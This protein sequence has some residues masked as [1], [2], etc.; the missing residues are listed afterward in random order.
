MAETG[1]IRATYTIPAFNADRCPDCGHPILQVECDTVLEAQPAAMSLHGA[2]LSL[3]LRAEAFTATARPCGHLLA[4][5]GEL[6]AAGMPETV[7]M[8]PRAPEPDW[9]RILHDLWNDTTL[10]PGPAPHWPGEYGPEP[11]FHDDPHPAA[12]RDR[13]ADPGRGVGPGR[14]PTQRDPAAQGQRAMSDFYADNSH[15]DAIDSVATLLGAWVNCFCRTIEPPTPAW[16]ARITGLPRTR[17]HGVRH[18]TPWAR[19]E[20]IVTLESH[21][22]P[23]MYGPT[24]RVI[25][26]KGDHGDHWSP[27]LCE[28]VRKQ[29]SLMV[30]GLPD[31]ATL[32]LRDP[33]CARHTPAPV[34]PSHAERSH[35]HHFPD[36][37]C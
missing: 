32:H 1:P 5:R 34:E 13:R 26:I 30:T 36:T 20:W 12:A 33:R 19:G 9:E 23:G 29:A 16:A 35:H 18:H 25:A 17:I 14:A 10:T 21:P 22:V 31:T 8:L 3:T 11:I 4:A 24:P 7:R 15:Y 27:E 6:P 37:P 2:E 28:Q